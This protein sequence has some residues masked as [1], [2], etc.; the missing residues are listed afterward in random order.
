VHREPRR[1]S[2]PNWVHASL[3]FSTQVILIHD[4]FKLAARRH[5][6]LRRV[7]RSN[8]RRA[9]AAA[10]DP[11]PGARS[12]SS[13]GVLSR[14]RERESRSGRS[15]ARRSAGAGRA[16]DAWGESETGSVCSGRVVRSSTVSLASYVAPA[17]SGLGARGAEGG[18]STPQRRAHGV[19]LSGGRV[20]VSDDEDQ[21]GVPRSLR[22]QPEQPSPPP[23]PAPSRAPAAYAF[24]PVPTA[25][26]PL[27]PALPRQRATAAAVGRAQA[28]EGDTKEELE[29]QLGAVA[30]RVSELEA[31][32]EVLEGRASLST[33]VMEKDAR[34][35]SALA[36]E[37]KV[38]ALDA[39]VAALQRAATGSA[40]TMPPSPSRAVHL[41]P[42]AEAI[43]GRVGAS[44]IARST[45][46]HA[47]PPFPA[48]SSYT[49]P[50]HSAALK[51]GA[52]TVPPS[53]AS[54]A[55]SAPSAGQNSSPAGPRNPA[56]AAE[57][58]DE[59]L[60]VF[61][62]PNPVFYILA[63]LSPALRQLLRQS[64][65][66]ALTALPLLDV[67]VS[68]IRERFRQTKELLESGR[69][70][71]SPADAAPHTPQQQNRTMPLGMTP[72][73]TAWPQAVA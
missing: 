30:A 43:S 56:A 70:S 61:V 64:D 42:S 65:A 14:S 54:T 2:S 67:Q 45:L 17:R 71:K 5:L 12:R 26:R 59:T 27:A 24:A 55:V 40:G 15:S 48:A 7:E 69:A 19:A 28:L 72:G 41:Q 50:A 73:G 1:A 63:S 33:G 8:S 16:R 13:S 44:E 49:I 21:E 9:Q 38:R 35:V 39:S 57:L 68:S 10:R 22:P 36:L 46:G 3:L 34:A 32:V 47:Q 58:S 20:S 66:P 23:P 37:G 31:R 60:R 29:E 6:E 52:G 62:S 51:S 53:A 18:A 4:I 25:V 11:S